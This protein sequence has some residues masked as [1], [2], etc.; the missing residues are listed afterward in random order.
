ME[1]TNKPIRTV[2]M[3]KFSISEFESKFGTMLNLQ[4]CFT[5]NGSDKLENQ[6]I[7]LSSRDLPL[8]KSLIKEWE[9]N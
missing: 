1:K 5:R 6:S 8:I 3:S 9:A 2:R 7:S 4:K